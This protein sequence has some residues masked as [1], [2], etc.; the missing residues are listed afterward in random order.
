MSKLGEAISSVLKILPKDEC[1]KRHDPETYWDCYTATLSLKGPGQKHLQ[2]KLQL[3][4]MYIKNMLNI[5][6]E[7]EAANSLS[8]MVTSALF[9]L[10]KEM[11]GHP[12]ETATGKKE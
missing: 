1:I 6:E 4:G 8:P 9:S 2:V 3:D 10:L 7:K 12:D 11:N 5:N